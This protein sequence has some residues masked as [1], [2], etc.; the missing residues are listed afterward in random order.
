MTP[1]QSKG[2]RPGAPPPPGTPSSS[3]ET[4]SPGTASGAP[5][6]PPPDE[7]GPGVA[8][9]NPPAPPE[10]LAGPL[11]PPCPPPPAMPPGAHA[12][13][14]SAAAVQRNARNADVLAIGTVG[15]C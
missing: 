14:I 8:P 12:A 3:L 1:I 15:N 2:G 9:P 5:S 13:Q 7:S 11:L 10:P 6:P 4:P